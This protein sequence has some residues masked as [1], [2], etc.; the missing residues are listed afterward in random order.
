MR[1][2][3]PIDRVSQDK[4]GIAS[5]RRLGGWA[6]ETQGPAGDA[7]LRQA[8]RLTD[9]V[10]NPEIGGVRLRIRR[11]ARRKP[12][13]AGARLV[14]DVGAESVRFVQGENLPQSA[15]VVTKPGDGSKSGW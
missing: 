15:A 3:K 5:T 7:D 12:I 14:D 11:G 13:E 10:E 9:A 1:A 8:D 4:R 6:A 2:V